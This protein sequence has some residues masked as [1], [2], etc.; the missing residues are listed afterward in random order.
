M[1]TKI[2]AQ[3]TFASL[4][5]GIGAQISSAACRWEDQG[6]EW[7]YTC[8]IDTSGTCRL[9]VDPTTGGTYWVC[10]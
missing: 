9:A 4:A 5:M 7:V 3:L 6:G 2:A 1:W 8:D 10:D